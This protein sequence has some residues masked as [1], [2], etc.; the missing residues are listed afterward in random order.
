MQNRHYRARQP[1][2]L[3]D[4]QASRSRLVRNR[5]RGSNS[6]RIPK[7]AAPAT[8][9]SDNENRSR[10]ELLD[11]GHSSVQLLIVF[12]LIAVAIGLLATYWYVGVAA[13][14]VFLLMRLVRYIRKERYFSSEEFTAHSREIAA[15]VGEHNEIVEYAAEI[16]ARGLFQLG[17]SSR[18]AQAHLASFENTSRHNYRRDR[19][20]ANYKASNVHNCSLQV[21]RNASADPIKYLI[22]YFNVRADEANLEEVER[23][24]DSIGRLEA[25]LDNLRQREAAITES[26]NPPRFILKHY[27]SQF[28]SRVGVE[29][30]PIEISYPLYVFEYVSAGGNSSQKTIVTL[31]TDTADALIET[32]GEKIRFRKSAAGQRALMT[33]KL[34]NLIKAR[35]N[36]TCQNSACGVS[37][38]QEPHLLLEVDHVLPV[39]KGGLSTSDNLQTL[40]WRCN[41]SKSNRL[42]PA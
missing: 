18:G 7:G 17:A 2:R 23:F 21:V 22:K 12:V 26:I 28:M 10:G 35:D 15:V 4:G 34:R 3:L 14:S 8:V 6:P 41:R 27:K 24:S 29:L 39:S 38:H 37:I 20:M 30:S 11:R 36:H 25:A 9:G 31:N 32:L 40:C 16:Q 5:Q 13:I 19:N 42:S 1:I 33:E